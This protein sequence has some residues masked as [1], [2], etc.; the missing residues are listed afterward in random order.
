M[1]DWVK[2]APVAVTVCD[3]EGKITEMNLKAGR[4]FEKRGGQALVGSNLLACHPEPAKTKLKGMLAGPE[5]ALNAYTIERNGVK[6]LIYQFS[7]IENGRSA[8][9]VEL[10]LELPPEMPNF[11]RK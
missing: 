4:I 3:R 6:K 11:V 1:N 10:S 7:R 8:G 5:A 9:L 2:E